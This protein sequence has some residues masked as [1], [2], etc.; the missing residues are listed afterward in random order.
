MGETVDRRGLLL[1]AR[2]L[3]AQTDEDAQIISDALAMEQV[4]VAS[5]DV[6]IVAA[7]ELE[8][9]LSAGGVATAA[10]G[11]PVRQRHG[12]PSLETA[13]RRIVA[14]ERE[15]A[16]VLS[17]TLDTLG[18]KPPTPPEGAVALARSRAQ[19]GLERSLDLLDTARAIVAVAIELENVQITRYLLAVRDLSDARLIALALQAMGAEGQHAT[20]LRGLLTDDAALAV[21][22]AFE[23]GSSSVP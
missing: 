15:H 23:R 17:S 12:R 10:A 3:F 2:D 22:E 5:Y 19:L 6:A 8:Q 9:E 1:A 13:L 18:A 7:H 16:E 21:P 14:Q 20:A 11:L 4:V